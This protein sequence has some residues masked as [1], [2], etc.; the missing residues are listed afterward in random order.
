MLRSPRAATALRPGCSLSAGGVARLV[1]QTPSGQHRRKPP[2]LVAHGYLTGAPRPARSGGQATAGLLARGSAPRSAFP[3]SMPSGSQSD[4]G[5]PPTVAGAAPDWG[6]GPCRLPFQVP[7]DTV[8]G[9]GYHGA[10]GPASGAR[11]ATLGFGRA[12]RGIRS[13]SSHTRRRQLGSFRGCR[14]A[15][16]RG[17]VRAGRRNRSCNNSDMTGHGRS[18]GQLRRQ[19]IRLRLPSVNRIFYLAMRRAACTRARVPNPRS[20]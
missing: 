5:S 16:P 1:G 9:I 2:T 12:R 11:P 17:F 8:V 7:K 10:R 4:R 20:R 15:W 18:R 6:Q 3:G 19:A 14:A 13:C